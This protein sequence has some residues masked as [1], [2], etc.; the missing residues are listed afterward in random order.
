M[1][2]P[3]NERAAEVLPTPQA[4]Q[5]TTQQAQCTPV[6]NQKRLASLRARA[7]MAGVRIHVYPD[8]DTGATVYVVSRWAQTRQLESLDAAERWLDMVCGVKS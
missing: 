3:T 7:A 2:H 6:R 4:A 8:S 5:E 1:N